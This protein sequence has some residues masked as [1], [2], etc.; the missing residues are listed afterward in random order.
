MNRSSHSKST[1][2][3]CFQSWTRQFYFFWSKRVKINKYKE[4]N[5]K[6]IPQC[7]WVFCSWNVF[8][9]VAHQLNV[10]CNLV[11]LKALKYSSASFLCVFEVRYW[12]HFLNRMKLAKSFNKPQQVTL[13]T[14]KMHFHSHFFSWSRGQIH[15]WCKSA[16]YLSSWWTSTDLHQ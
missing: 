16:E 13:R 5:G 8:L 1:A 9:H 4:R 14:Q 12:S 10:T 6:K 7:S 2:R 11:V 15:N 3:Y